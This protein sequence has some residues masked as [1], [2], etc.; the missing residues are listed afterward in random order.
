MNIKIYTPGN[1]KEITDILYNSKNV[2]FLAGGTDLV[3][4][5]NILKR[6]GI[7]L[8]DLSHVAELKYIKKKENNIYIGSMTTFSELLE[9]KIILKYLPILTEA[10]KQ[11]GSIQIRNMATIGGNIANAS[12]AADS[13]PV[14]LVLDARIKVLSGNNTEIISIDEIIGENGKLILNSDYLITEIILPLL[15]SENHFTYFKKIGNRKNVTIA[16]LN[17]GFIINFSKDTKKIKEAKI[18]LGALGRKAF[19]AFEVEKLLIGKLIYKELENKFL[20]LLTDTV[21]IAIPG[22]YS[23]V[24]KRQAIRSIGDDFINAYKNYLL[25][26][27][28]RD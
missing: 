13:L 18:A 6:K 19:R 17:A 7:S 15:N 8:I 12:P 16:R 25:K 11:L 27:E 21:D 4:S 10:S 9:N 20:D 26:G 1:M 14:L 22:R 24:Y 28:E 3:P 2:K 23:Q 5:L